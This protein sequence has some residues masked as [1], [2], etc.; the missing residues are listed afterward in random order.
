[1]DKMRQDHWVNVNMQVPVVNTS[2]V[3]RDVLKDYDNEKLFVVDDEGFLSLIYNKVVYSSLAKDF[4]TL[5]TQAFPTDNYTSTDVNGGATFNKVLPNFDSFTGARID[6]IKYDTLAIKISVNNTFANAGALTIEFPNLTKNGSPAILSISNLNGTTT[7]ELY[8]YTLDL[9]DGGTSFNTIKYNYIFGTTWNGTS[10][11]NVGITVELSKN[12]Y[13]NINGFIGQHDVPLPGDSVHVDIFDKE[14]DGQFYFKNPKIQFNM[15]NSYGLPIRLQLGSIQ[16]T[17]FDGNQSPVYNIGLDMNPVNY[18]NIK[19]ET[20]L[21]SVLF[22]TLSA[23]WIRDL[24]SYKPKYIHFDGDGFT[25]PQASIINNFVLDTSRF[26]LRMKFILPLW[27]RAE[28]P[29]L[30]DTSDMDV[31]K[32]LEYVDDVTYLKIKLVAN[33]GLAAEVR[34]QAYFVDSLG[35]IQDSLFSTINEQI[36]IE[37]GYT[38]ETGKVIQKRSKITEIV[39]TQDRIDKMKTVKKVVYVAI[40]STDD[41]EKLKNVKFYADDAIDLKMGFH[42]KGGSDL[43]YDSDTT[44]TN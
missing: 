42:V 23:P 3:L 37:G 32:E 28:Y 15:M 30:T 13:K 43:Q 16:G 5:P 12:D 4:I 41:I 36:V 34:V 27:G 10:G 20:A 11:Q 40:V 17:D 24:I 29:S 2:L 14:F 1:M 39:Y 6:S 44:S 18:P 35:V 8:G 19:G 33:N 9:T 25:N 31:E 22:D 7:Q 26:D 38:D 21:D